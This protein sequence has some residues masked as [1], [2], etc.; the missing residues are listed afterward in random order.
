MFMIIVMFISIIRIIVTITTTTTTTTT[1][2]SIVIS[3]IHKSLSERRSPETDAAAH[4]AHVE[5]PR[6]AQLLSRLYHSFY[7]YVY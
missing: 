6:D 5:L 2:T 4:D 1:T 7:C 3:T